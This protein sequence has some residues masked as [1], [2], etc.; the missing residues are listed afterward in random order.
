MLSPM[1]YAGLSIPRRSGRTIFSLLPQQ[2]HGKRALGPVM[3]IFSIG[4]KIAKL[5]GS[6]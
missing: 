4:R 2:P 3:P 1:K 5:E 6:C